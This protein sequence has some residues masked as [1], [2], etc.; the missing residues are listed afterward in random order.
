MP[1]CMCVYM[2]VYKHIYMCVCI[3]IFVQKPKNPTK[4]TRII[5]MQL[6]KALNLKQLQ[7]E[8]EIPCGWK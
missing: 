6:T 4:I 1:D 2:C 3:Y 8:T 5:D 7:A